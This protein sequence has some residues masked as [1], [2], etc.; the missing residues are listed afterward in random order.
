MLPARSCRQR[1]SIRQ[2]NTSALPMKTKAHS[3]RLLAL[4][5]AA[6]L[7]GSTAA[8][9]QTLYVGGNGGNT[10]AAY[11]ANTGTLIPSF[12]LPVANPTGLALSGNTLY[13]AGNA[14]TSVGTYNA[15]TGAAINTNLISG[16][17]YNLAL[18]TTDLYTATQNGPVMA[19]N[20]VTGLQD[21]RFH[22]DPHERVRRG[23][24]CL[25]RPWWRATPST[26]PARTPARWA[27]T[28]RRPAR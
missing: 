9:A 26:S 16:N 23:Q 15:T 24:R 17:Y 21:P 1:T 22:H 11:N 18:G 12:S 2:K 25:V 8:L 19:F 27:R 13:V 7:A 10:V 14:G 20:A 6:I 4:T 28:T 3:L 5:G